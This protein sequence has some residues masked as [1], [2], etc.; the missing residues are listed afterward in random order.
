MSSSTRRPLPYDFA[1]YDDQGQL[2]VLL[3][4]YGR[5]GLS[6]SWAREWHEMAAE[7]MRSPLEAMVM[8]VS[9]DK[10][11][12]WRRRAE[13]SAEP[14]WEIEA[15]PLFRPYFTRT[16]ISAID[17]FP[18][19]FKQIVLM[20]LNDVANRSFSTAADEPNGSPLLQ[21]LRGGEII[22]QVAA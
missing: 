5:P 12:V 6:R 15:T 1:I 10:I 22:E 18:S 8:L 3:D 11:Y 14:D 20:W 16:K 21:P 13:A 9:L 19:I 2:A 7:R 17:V 4:T